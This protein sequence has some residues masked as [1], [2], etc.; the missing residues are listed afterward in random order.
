[1]DDQ[2]DNNLRNRIREVFDNYED[3]HADEGWLLLREKY[4]EEEKRR[5]VAWLWWGSVAASLLLLMG[6]VW[7]N[8][9]PAHKENLL[10]GKK[11]HS[12]HLPQKTTE[13]KK[14][15]NIK[16]ENERA[17]SVINSLQSQALADNA[18]HSG[19]AT[20]T[21]L[22]KSNRQSITHAGA[23]QRANSIDNN[24]ILATNS[25]HITAKR[26][27]ENNETQDE[28]EVTQARVQ[29]PKV[30]A[31]NKSGKT[32]NKAGNA[33]DETDDN[34]TLAVDSG[35]KAVNSIA[36]AKQSTGIN[37]QEETKKANKTLFADNDEPLNKKQEKSKS[38]NKAVQ[39]GVYEATYVNYA[40][41]SSNQ[42]NVGAGVSSDI[43]LSRNLNLSTGVS[44][45]QNTF[46]YGS[47]VP[48]VQEK[49]NA[50]ALPASFSAANQ[51]AFA[52]ATPSLKNYNANLVGL[53]VPINL[54]YAFNPEKSASYVSIGLSS[55]TFI[56][57]TYTSTYTYSTPFASN[58][59]QTTDQSIHQSFNSFYFAKTLN[60]SFGTGY[61]LGRNQLIIEPFL[62]YPL[63]GL[64]SQQIRFGAGGLNLK[65]NFKTHK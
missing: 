27:A 50:A 8:Y 34:N 39:F 32:L 9:T 18:L 20:K 41:G 45:A 24:N 13:S 58:L 11:Q 36:A 43:K 47:Q 23:D 54:K 64:G 40:K 3:G 55:G 35:T 37:M 65:F 22:V 31:A 63:E 49:L 57:E 46:S 17:D 16:N 62:K 61:T 7:H 51:N 59:S 53:D 6:I 48:P 10:T 19:P 4:P 56:N 29:N 26:P 5:P 2:L 44:I 21:T 42:V 33:L 14:A 1:M 12:A 60:F 30:I 52:A 38:T 15:N 25:K 28:T